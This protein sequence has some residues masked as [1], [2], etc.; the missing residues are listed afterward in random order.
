MTQKHITIVAFCGPSGSGKSELI[1]RLLDMYPDNVC[2]WKQATTRA[3]RGPNDDYVFM[4]KPMYDVVRSTLTCR[5]E[6]NGNFY[7]TFPEL[8]NA[9]TAV[10]TI[11]D[12]MGLSDL[13]ADVENH[14]NHVNNGHVG[15]LGLH[16]VKLVTVLMT[17][18]LTSADEVHKRGA[19]RNGTRSGE[20]LQAEEE[21][22]RAVTAFDHVL[23]STGDR[24]TQPEEFFSGAIWPA[25]CTP[26]GA[27]T[28]ESLYAQIE[29]QLIEVGEGCRAVRDLDA[30]RGV[31]A[32]LRGAAEYVNEWIN[33][34]PE[35][36]NDVDDIDAVL[37]GAAA[38]IVEAAAV[39]DDDTA[40]VDPH[41]FDEAEEIYRQSLARAGD[42]EEEEA[43]QQH[44]SDYLN[45]RTPENTPDAVAEEPVPE[46][47]L[48]VEADPVEVAAV[49]PQP[50]V[51]EVP[52][53]ALKPY[54]EIFAE[55]DFTDWMLDNTIGLEAFEDEAKFKLIFSQ[56]VSANGGN[57]NDIQVG[58]QA[59][60]DGKGGRVVGYTAIMPDGSR[61]G[62]EFNERIKQVVKYGPL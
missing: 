54:A 23:D 48:T 12:A 47:P 39:V 18:D 35:G 56:Y 6:F 20:F 24:W 52:T 51:E 7:G 41:G 49:E 31:L 5:T 44:P 46:T 1:Q 27:D 29:H 34:E 13:F 3:K 32:I 30:L 21:K 2:K 36:G 57:P 22:L 55:S 59:T 9:D 61:Y 50:V 11:A 8:V 17:Y 45:D 25:I 60:K 58:F 40:L 4:T 43:E 28:F 15:K 19:D 14:N 26:L 16:P 38:P 37:S 33:S 42:D 62:V 53:A 10:L